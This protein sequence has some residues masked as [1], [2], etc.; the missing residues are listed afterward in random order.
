MVCLLGSVKGLILEREKQAVCRAK[1]AACVCIGPSLVL[2]DLM[3][4]LLVAGDVRS[5][6]RVTCA[7]PGPSS[8]MH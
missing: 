8:H 4:M 6:A 3:Q 2:S 1:S 5:F 7:E